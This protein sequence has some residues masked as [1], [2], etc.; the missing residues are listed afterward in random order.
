MILPM[1][2]EVMSVEEALQ[3]E[4]ALGAQDLYYYTTKILEV[5]KD[6]T[7]VRPRAEIEP[8][9]EWLQK[10]R[11]QWFPKNS[12]WKRF[13]ALP[14]GTA[15]TTLVKSYVAWRIHRNPNIRVYYTSEEKALSLDITESIAD[16]LTCERSEALY[17]VVRGETGWQVGKGKYKVSTC[18]KRGQVDPT[19]MAGGVDVSAQGRHPDLII[20][21]D[22]QGLTNSSV[23]GIEK[24]KQ[25]LRLLWPVLNPGGELIWICTRW[26]YADAASS[27]LKERENDPLAWDA[28]EGRGFFGSRAVDGDEKFFPE[29]EVSEPLFPSILDAEELR[30]LKDG[31][32]IYT[33]S[34]QYDNNPIDS[35]AAYFKRA[36]FQYVGEYDAE[37]PI[38]Q[39]L[40]FYMAVDPASGI[41][42]VKRG[43]DTAIVIIGVKGQKRERQIYVMDTVGGQFKP[44]RILDSM[45]SL[46]DKWRPKSVALE[47]AGPGKMFYAMLREHMRNEVIWLPIREVTHAGTS[48]SKADRIA[49]VEP[50]YRTHSVFHCSHL[51]G[52]ILEDQLERFKPGGGAH[53]DYPDALS[54]ALEV[55]KEGHAK[56]QPTKAF[57]THQP[58][59]RSTNY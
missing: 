41:E 16:M 6:S 46:Y 13:L 15:K 48:E 38:F 58:R 56:K 21:D 32:N 5:G 37:N 45:F 42:S 51:K 10:D 20:A 36:D 22:L 49:K 23:E 17:G 53:N 47:T 31:M 26:D 57:T 55:V 1:T 44:S 39:G 59:Y 9:C 28:P 29:A 2:L 35:E 33:F 11:P 43:D 7:V 18:T 25:Y 34:C 14:R 4:A 50:F 30:K 40:V 24:I 54:M 27:I 52:G 19:L 8:I 3:A 12:R